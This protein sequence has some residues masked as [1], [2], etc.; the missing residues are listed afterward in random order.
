MRKKRVAAS[1][2]GDFSALNSTL[3][4]RWMSLLCFF[5][6][7]LHSVR[8]AELAYL[9]DAMQRCVFT[10]CQFGFVSAK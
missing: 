1:G 6:P 4:S 10:F 9:E 8:W 7:L 3:A 2:G 5:G